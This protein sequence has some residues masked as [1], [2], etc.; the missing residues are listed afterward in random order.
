MKKIISAVI[1]LLCF[2][3]IKIYR[4][5]TYT[6]FTEDMI[7][8]FMTDEER[9]EDAVDYMKNKYGTDMFDDHTAIAEVGD[10]REVMIDLYGLDRDY[11]YGINMDMP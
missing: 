6:P 10:L 1:C 11:V 8:A 5:A 3:G 2:A 7:P 9:I 4:Y